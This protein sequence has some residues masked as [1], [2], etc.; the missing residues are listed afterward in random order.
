MKRD[1]EFVHKKKCTTRNKRG[2]NNDYVERGKIA[3]KKE[4]I[5]NG[6]E[7]FT[8]SKKSMTERDEARERNVEREIER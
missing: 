2:I 1:R 6:K 7:W 8:P 5:R 4:T 3:V